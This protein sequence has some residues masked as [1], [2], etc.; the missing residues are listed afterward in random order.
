MVLKTTSGVSQALWKAK[1][2]DDLDYL[3]PN[4]FKFTILNSPQVSFFCQSA[5][6]PQIGIGFIDYS[7]PLL[8]IPVPGEKLSFSDLT[9]KFIV[10][11]N[12]EN[13]LEIY[14]WLV[15]LG[16]PED[17]Q[18]Y[19]DW[20]KTQSFRFPDVPDK[21]LGALGNFSDA[22]LV[23][24]DSDN[25]ANVSITFKDIFPYSLEGLEFDISSGTAQYMTAV[26][27][28]KYSLYTIEKL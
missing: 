21:R 23:I 27:S 28:F 9:I 2:P 22:T 13:Y 14:N 7:N 20:Q 15:G 11:E 19:V 4:G 18:Q 6:I 10:Q 3:R 24:L 5:N 12:M 25:N 8:N 16:A 17:K 26:A 1:Q